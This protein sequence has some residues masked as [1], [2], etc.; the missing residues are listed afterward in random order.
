VRT[1]GAVGGVA[2]DIYGAHWGLEV[3][4]GLE[5]RVKSSF[6]GVQSQVIQVQSTAESPSQ[7]FKH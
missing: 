1:R 2:S 5:V 7:E 4:L 6:S 3:G